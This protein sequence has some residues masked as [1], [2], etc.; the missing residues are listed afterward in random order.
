MAGFAQALSD[1]AH[2]SGAG[3]PAW[4]R[5]GAIGRS[6]RETQRARLARPNLRRRRQAA[7]AAAVIRPSRA[8]VVRTWI[9][10]SRGENGKTRVTF[11]WEPIPKTPGDSAASRGGDP[12]RVSVMAMAPDGS[13]VFRGRVPDVA[14]ASTS[15]AGI[16]AAGQS[17]TGPRGSSRIT[18]DAPPGKIQ[19][20]LSVEG[21]GSGAAAAP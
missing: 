15:S 7:I 6:T 8:T 20:R 19:L 5:A 9:G 17:A 2:G 11:V 18:F 4:V 16:A 3:D 14:V 21:A 10:T 1:G 12:V 13:P